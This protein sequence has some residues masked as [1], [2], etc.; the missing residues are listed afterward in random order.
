MESVKASVDKKSAYRSIETEDA[1]DQ[2]AIRLLHKYRE[3][4]IYRKELRAE[5]MK[6]EQ[7]ARM[8]EMRAERERIEAEAR[9]EAER[10]AREEAEEKARKEAEAQA[11]KNAEEAERKAREERERWKN[12]EDEENEGA[13]NSFKASDSEK[14]EAFYGPFKNHGVDFSYDDR[15]TFGQNMKVFRSRF[16]DRTGTGSSGHDGIMKQFNAM[17]DSM[18]QQKPI[19]L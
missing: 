10:R 11:R 7:E 18:D 15:K 5:R 1:A 9:K 6:A 13:R 14:Q 2:F 8:A 16:Y 19:L 4:E 17:M 3:E 12:W